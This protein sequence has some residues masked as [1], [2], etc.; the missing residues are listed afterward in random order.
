LVPNNAVTSDRSVLSPSIVVPAA[1]AVILE[2]DAYHSF[3]TDDPSGC[4]DGATIE[5]KSDANPFAQLGSSR[6][7]TDSYDG[8]F[9]AGAPRAG[10]AGWCRRASGLAA[11]HSIVDLDDFAG[12][13]VQLRF[14]ATSDS[15][16]TA[17]APNG[18]VID[19]VKVSVCQ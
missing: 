8:V 12:H 2:Y 11:K 9:S 13:S 14:R 10:A 17:A 3:E 5:L 19:N 16:T 18:M 6:F 7:F 15:N 1:Q 4:W